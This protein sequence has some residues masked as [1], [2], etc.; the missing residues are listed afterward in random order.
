M[1]DSREGERARI[2]RRDICLPLA[3]ARTRG[4]K[5]PSKSPD[6]QASAALVR[7]SECCRRQRRVS[8]G[9]YKTAGACK[10]T[11]RIAGARARA[12]AKSR[13]PPSPIVCSRARLLIVSCDRASLRVFASF[14]AKKYRSRRRRRHRRCHSSRSRELRRRRLTLE[15][16]CVT[17][18]GAKLQN[19]C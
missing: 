16:N 8:S 12:S 18:D 19:S 5:S 9:A 3:S 11:A 2:E 13:R 6:A 10:I 1:R 17:S 7:V 14:R 15:E 4:L